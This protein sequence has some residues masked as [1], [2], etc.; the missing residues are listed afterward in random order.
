MK[1]LLLIVLTLSATL[2]EAR[3]TRCDATRLQPF[4]GA[5]ATA[6]L[7][8]VILKRSRARTLRWLPPGVMVTMD[9][10]L[11]RLNVRLDPRN[12]VTGIDCG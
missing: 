6:D 7:G 9:F 2:A 1:T 8:P 10:R 5:L 12:F 11:D 3:P 4:V